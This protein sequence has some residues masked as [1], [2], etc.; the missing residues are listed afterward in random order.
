MG[1]I[2]VLIGSILMKFTNIL[3]ID[4]ILSIG[5]ALF[6]L[7]NAFKN[8]KFIIDIFLEKTPTNVDIKQIMAH[9]LRL[10]GVLGI[11][12]IHVRSMDGYNNFATLHVIVKE[13]SHEIKEKIKAELKEHNIGHST[14]ELELKDEECHEKNCKI[15]KV[16]NN[17]HHNH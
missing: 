16:E 15:R 10:D 6:I 11:H 2:V 8:L 4:S 3:Y 9:L 14:I 17:H 7:I 5:V 1:W 13:Y 12:H